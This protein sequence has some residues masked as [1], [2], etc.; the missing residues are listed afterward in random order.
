MADNP[1]ANL[2]PR[3]SLGLKLLLVCL[4]V[5]VMAI[6]LFIVG[7][8][9]NDRQTRANQVTAEIG[10][11]AG[12]AQIVGGPMLLVPYEHRT[13]WTDD[14]GQTQTRTDRGSYLI[15]AETGT[16]NTNLHV[17]DRHHGIY[18]AAVYTATTD[19]TAHFRP[20]EALKNVDPSFALNW[21]AARFVMFVRDS[22]AIRDAAELR[23]ADGTTATLE[24][25]SDF[26][27]R[28]AVST[29]NGDRYIPPADATL[30]AFAAPAPF[31]APPAEFALTTHLVLG[32]AQRFSLAAFAQDTSARIAGDRTDV[33]A[34]GYFQTV[35]PLRPLQN[36]FTASWRVPF[37]ARGVDKAVDLATFN[38]DTLSSRDMAVSFVSANDV[39]RG[40]ARAVSYGIMFIGIVFLATLIFE[41]V[42]GRKAHPAQYILVGLAQCVFYL[43]LLSI[44]ELLG[45][46]TAFIIA[47]AA[48]VLLLAY[49]A[50]ASFR[51]ASVGVKSLFG[52]TLLYGAMYVLMTLE[53]FGMLAGSLVAFLVI[54]ATMIAT[55][56]IDWYGRRAS[57]EPLAA[58]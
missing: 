1:I 54:A 52:L 24:P 4:L 22:R 15:F 48:T 36:N 20:Q 11:G 51:S 50:G 13:Q 28:A 53:D 6:P 26:Q 14:R 16:A 34:D 33:S 56:R 47:A 9:V 23:F 55:R 21:N 43:L 46:D 49:Y 32:G 27:V 10:E 42:S 39:Y 58:K 38:L 25:M 30:Q 7:L 5:L 31:T 45:F 8:Q 2:I 40:V 12:G 41:A 18:R 17:E 37:V 19:F 44:T 35:D 57:A 3:G 29:P